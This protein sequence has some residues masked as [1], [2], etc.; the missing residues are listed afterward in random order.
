VVEALV[1]YR[2]LTPNLRP[3]TPLLEPELHSFL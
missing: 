1:L 2:K 3:S